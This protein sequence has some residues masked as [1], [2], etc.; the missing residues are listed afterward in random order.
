M[1]N[2]NTSGYQIKSVKTPSEIDEVLTQ[3]SHKA[4]FE[5]WTETRKQDLLPLATEIDPSRIP[6]LLK[7]IAIFDVLDKTEVRYRLAGTSIAERMGAD[8]TGQNV[9]EML[10]PKTRE[11]ISE[12]IEAIINQPVGVLVKYETVHQGGKRAALESLYLPL[13][14]T[15]E[16][17]PRVLSTHVQQKILGYEEERSA[18]SVAEAITDVI[19]IDIGAGVP[20]HP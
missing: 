6:H 9:I 18:T 10:S 7:D 8:P 2:A 15:E 3:P 1:T 11:F 12:I 20:P 5:F 17:S 13:G 16:T 14:R 4:L 19:W